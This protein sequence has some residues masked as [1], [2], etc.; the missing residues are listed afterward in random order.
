MKKIHINASKE[1]DVIISSGILKDTG[2]LI[3]DVLPVSRAAVIS[4]DKVFSLYGETVIRSLT[5]AGFSAVSYFI[6]VFRKRYKITPKEYQNKRKREKKDKDFFH[7]CSD[8][9]Y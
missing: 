5:D 8:F 4:D 6:S 2:K 1:Y 9:I 7:N 3:K